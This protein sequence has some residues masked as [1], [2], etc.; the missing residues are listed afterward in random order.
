M[1]VSKEQSTEFKGILICMMIFLHL[2]DGNHIGLCTNSIYVG[3]K[4]FA[5]WLHNACGPVGFFLLL[6]GYGLAYTYNKGNLTFPK[7][8]KRLY[9]LYVNFFVI[10][11]LFVSIG[12]IISD[13][14]PGSL[15]DFILNIIGWEYTYN[16]ELWFFFP[17]CIIS[18][19]SPFIIRGINYVGNV[20]ALLITA[21]IH[22]CTCYI[23]S[24]YGDRY[25]YNNMFLYRPFQP[26]HFLYSFTAGVVLYRIKEIRWFFPSWVTL[27]FII[28]LVC[29]VA[30]CNT[31][32]I[33]ILY[34]PLLIFLLC[35]I[36]FPKYLKNV[37]LELGHKSMPMWMIHTWFCYYLFQQQVYSLHYPILIFFAVT[38]ISYLTAVPIMWVTKKILR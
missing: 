38:A 21:F 26:F 18:L 6:S 34:E 19:L 1:T 24:R 8:L 32:P 27:L 9:K 30:T 4:P 14:Y 31:A 11:L 37:L 10:L 20:R 33:Y 36:T 35:Q 29:I 5:L 2:F 13:A 25:L 16:A 7:Q 17:Y 23:I 28:L 3:S 12:S 15:K 22:I